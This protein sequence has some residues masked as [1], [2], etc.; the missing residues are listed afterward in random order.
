MHRTPQLH[1]LRIDAL[2]AEILNILY[3]PENLVNGHRSVMFALIYESWYILEIFPFS[4][5][6]R[7]AEGLAIHD[8]FESQGHLK[9]VAQTLPKFAVNC[10]VPNKANK[11]LDRLGVRAMF[12]PEEANFS[13][14]ADELVFV[15]KTCA[16]GCVEGHFFGVSYN[17]S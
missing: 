15:S 17:I 12:S 4:V 8:I 5:E 13:N 11:I 10:D 2:E 14:L 3:A 16:Q 1:H 6:S 7:M 9:Q